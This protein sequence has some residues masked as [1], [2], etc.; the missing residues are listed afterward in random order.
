[1]FVDFVVP[2]AEVDRGHRFGRV[3]FEPGVEG[4]GGGAPAERA[5]GSVVVV[6]VDEPVELGLQLGE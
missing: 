2:D 4:I 6:V 3:G 1:M 5:V